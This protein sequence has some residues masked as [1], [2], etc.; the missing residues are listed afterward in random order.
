MSRPDITHDGLA[1]LYDLWVE[2]RGSRALPDRHDFGPEPL[3]P[4]L[5]NLVLIDVGEGRQYRYRLYGSNFVFR[6]GVEMTNRTVDDL[7]PEQAAAIRR[8]YDAVVASAEPLCRRYTNGFDIIDIHRRLNAQRVETWERLVLPL[9]NGGDGVAMLMIA[10][11]ELPVVAGAEPSGP[12][13]RREKG[14][15]PGV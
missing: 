14:P 9:S 15:P 10:A 8:D 2:K 13:P 1:R 12:P 11:Y 7:P 5:G 4:W 3:R 6:F